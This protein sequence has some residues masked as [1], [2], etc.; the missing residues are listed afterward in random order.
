MS[1][2]IWQTTSYTPAT[3]CLHS[4]LRP[5]PPHQPHPTCLLPPAL[6]APSRHPVM[7]TPLIDG[8]S[9]LRVNLRS[10]IMHGMMPP[11]HSVSHHG[12]RLLRRRNQDISLLLA[13]RLFTDNSG[14]GGAGIFRRRQ[15]E[16]P[17]CPFAFHYWAA[18][19]GKHYEL[20]TDT[21]TGHLHKRPFYLV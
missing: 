20:V 4:S 16:W 3:D 14:G 5:S 2:S 7:A 12:A 19:N 10:W 13:T 18:E 6:R 8:L 17:P 15:L 21:S 11:L 9:P 1:H